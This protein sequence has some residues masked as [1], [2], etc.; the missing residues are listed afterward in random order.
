MDIDRQHRL[1]L[2]ILIGSA[3]VDQHLEPEEIQYLGTLIR[4]YQLD[5][6][7][8]LLALL[9]FPVPPEQ[10]E[11]WMIAYFQD[12]TNAERLKLLADMGRI[13]IAD[14]VVTDQEHDLLDDYHELMARIP[15]HPDEVRPQS[16]PG[17]EK[18]YGGA[19]THAEAA[20]RADQA[21]AATLVQAVGKFVRRAIQELGKLASG[22]L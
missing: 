11:R 17:V 14:D 5:H 21:S 10:T 8:E 1:A 13:L 6:D 19:A 9:Q 4:R 16:E 3:W 2:K 12:T 22:S 15:A 20:S 7:Q 18:D